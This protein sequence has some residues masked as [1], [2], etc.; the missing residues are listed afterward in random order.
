MKVSYEMALRKYGQELEARRAEQ[1]NCFNALSDQ[2]L[3]QRCLAGES[4]A[5]GE[6]FCRYWQWACIVARD[7]LGNDAYAE[8]AVAEAFGRAF[9]ALGDFQRQSSFRTWLYR[10]VFHV[11]LDI[12][13]QTKRRRAREAR[14]AACRPAVKNVAPLD[15][16]VAKEQMQLISSALSRWA[17]FL[18]RLVWR[19]HFH[20]D[21]TYPEIAEIFPEMTK[22]QVRY[23]VD[24]LSRKLKRQLARSGY[25][26]TS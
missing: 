8:D 5:F 13:R 15:T 18:E 4:T 2:Q 7:I 1:E 6:L 9:A 26:L 3:L 11:A 12:K 17:T 21:M 10:I 25:S 22:G 16:L 23:I 14:T 20:E 19:L 24:K